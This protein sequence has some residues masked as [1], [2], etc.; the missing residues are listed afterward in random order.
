ME[1]YL[2]SWMTDA[3]AQHQYDSAIYVGD[4]LLAITSTRCSHPSCHITSY[5]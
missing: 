2:R 5:R 4:K 1:A 3:L